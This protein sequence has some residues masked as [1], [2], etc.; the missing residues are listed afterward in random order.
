MGAFVGLA[1]KNSKRESTMAIFHRLNFRFDPDPL[2]SP[3]SG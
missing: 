3:V 1:A 2:R